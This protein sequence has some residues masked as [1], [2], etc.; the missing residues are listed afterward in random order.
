MKNS[1]LFAAVQMMC[2]IISFLLQASNTGIFLLLAA[3]TGVY[4]D[5]PLPEQAFFGSCDHM[6]AIFTDKYDIFMPCMGFNFSKGG[7][8]FKSEIYGTN[9]ISSL[10]H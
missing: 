5:S 9:N 3:E 2:A 8:L 4:A 7:V 6:K 1:P 10:R